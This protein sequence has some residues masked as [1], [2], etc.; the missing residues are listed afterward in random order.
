MVYLTVNI[1][2]HTPSTLPVLNT[3]DRFII[4]LGM[5]T[6][7][8]HAQSLSLRGSREDDLGRVETEAIAEARETR[9]LL[10]KLRYARVAGV[11]TGKGVRF[12][13]SPYAMKSKG[14]DS[15][16]GGLYSFQV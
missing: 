6:P 5:T 2:S 16:S 4:G 11:P 12:I 13:F 7:R 15:S 3:V 10:Y 1:P 14:S 9:I 8:C